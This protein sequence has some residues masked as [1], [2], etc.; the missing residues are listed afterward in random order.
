MLTKKST[1]LL[2][3]AAAVLLVS[4][5]VWQRDLFA[6]LLDGE[7]DSTA[8]L[9][10][11]REPLLSSGGWAPLIY[12]AIVVVEVVVAPIPG[13]FL[14]MPGGAIFGGALGGTLAL[15][16]NTLGAGLAAYLLRHVISERAIR[17]WFDHSRFQRSRELIEARGLWIVIALR[18]N[19]LTSCDLVSYAAAL[20]PM[21]IRTLMFG[22]FVGMA[23]L[24]YV[25]SYMVQSVFTVF[26]W[27]LWPMIA[28]GIGYVIAVIWVL[29]S[30]SRRTARSPERIEAHTASVVVDASRETLP[31]ER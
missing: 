23:P 13:V 10:T 9:N 8:K 17:G 14:Y 26:P 11:V 22:T 15:I 27:L 1:F 5:V 25:Q 2:F 24:C 28:L 7:V 4:A 3:A 30:L 29:R 20:T 19:P 18:L 6:L 31:H 16:G 12:V 21:R